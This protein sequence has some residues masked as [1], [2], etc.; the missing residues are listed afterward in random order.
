MKLALHWQILIAIILGIVFG[1][2]FYP[3]IGY[4]GW[5]GQL[6]LRALNMLVL[7]LIFCSIISAIGNLPDGESLKRMGFKTIGF[8]AG[9]TLLAILTGMVFVTLL[10]PGVGLEMPSKLED[11]QAQ[12]ATVDSDVKQEPVIKEESAPQTA[13]ADSDGKQELSEKVKKIQE[14]QKSFGE[15]LMNMIP[16]NVVE[17]MAKGNMLPVI[18]FAFLA[19]TLIHSIPSSNA[20][21]LKNFFRSCFE[22]MMQMTLLVVRLAPIGVFGLIA[23]QC[24]QYAG[25][26]EKL[27]QAAGS[28]GMFMITCFLGMGF[29]FFITLSIVLIVFAKVNPIRHMV[30]MLPSLMTA[31]STATS[32]ATIPLSMECLEKNSGVSRQTSGFV[33]P[34]GATLNMNGTALY[35]CVIVIF[36]SQAYGLPLTLTDQV[37][38]VTIVM[39]AAAGTAGIPMASF[40]MTAIAL[41]AVGLPLE[42]L[43]V[44]LA[45]DR[46]LDMTR[47]TVNIYG[48]TC[49]A[50][51]IAR[52]EGEELKE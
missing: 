41:R 34:L 48:D 24:A 47:T 17:D 42:G 12:I 28:L 22:L 1:V 23:V 35:E 26:S 6:F 25:D 40:V 45:I 13:T 38:M 16:N 10:R 37:V 3:Y 49:C 9:T 51:Y 19:G 43:G 4:V 14:Q 5:T 11:N 18:F 21:T 2:Y 50:V 46:I 20:Q 30:N 8:Y 15:L 31:F 29:H 52:S 27:I 44:I 32:N 33:I 36:M 7:P 39:L